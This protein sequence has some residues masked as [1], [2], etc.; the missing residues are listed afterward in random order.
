MIELFPV[1]VVLV[2]SIVRLVKAASK[3][4][5]AEALRTFISPTEEWGPRLVIINGKYGEKY[6]MW[7]NVEIFYT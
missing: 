7:R 1:F 5:L 3:G 2:F 4:E 6:V